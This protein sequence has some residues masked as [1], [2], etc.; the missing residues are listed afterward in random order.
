MVFEEKC[1]PLAP[2]ITHFLIRAWNFLISKYCF[3]NHW[4][5]RVYE[6]HCTL[7]IKQ[8]M[9]LYIVTLLEYNL[10]IQTINFSLT[11]EKCGVHTKWYKKNVELLSV[12]SVSV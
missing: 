6:V 9:L 7:F 8:F 11:R 3:L 5:I 10:S 12:I 4:E 1:P 2:L